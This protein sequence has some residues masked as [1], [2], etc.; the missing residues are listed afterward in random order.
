MGIVEFD[1]SQYTL[2]Y[3]PQKLRALD[4]CVISC[5]SVLTRSVQKNE[6][7]IDLD[8]VQFHQDNI[9]LFVELAI[10]AGLIANRVLLNFMGIKL[11]NSG[12]TNE[13]IAL[14]IEAFDL[15]PIPV[16]DA[17]KILEGKFPASELEKLWVESLSTASRSIAHF[18]ER[19]SQISVARLG[20]ACYATSL[21]VRKYFLELKLDADKLP[22]TIVPSE[23]IPILGSVWNSVDPSATRMC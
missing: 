6:L 19:G 1:S 13:K 7:N 2:E 18:T 17:V 20:Y 15:Q 14:N 4:A 5:Y 10:D 9:D 22:P 8:T 21:L 16:S 3:L 11:D 23:V 12:L